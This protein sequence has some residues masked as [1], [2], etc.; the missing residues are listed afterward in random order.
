[1]TMMKMK[2]NRHKINVARF[3]RSSVV[4]AAALHHLHLSL[5]T[6]PLH[7]AAMYSEY[8]KSNMTMIGVCVCVCVF[9]SQL[10][11]QKGVCPT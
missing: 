1:M 11:T 4:A 6:N 7:C 10:N 3:C 8:L 2:A 5:Y 9:G